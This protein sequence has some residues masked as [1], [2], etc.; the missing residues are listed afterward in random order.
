MS[1]RPY[2]ALDGGKGDQR[3]EQQEEGHEIGGEEDKEGV[4]RVVSSSMGCR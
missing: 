3:R 4:E 1:H 2:H